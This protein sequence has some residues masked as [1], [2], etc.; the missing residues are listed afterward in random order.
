[1]AFYEPSD[2]CQ[3]PSGVNV[4]KGE[5]IISTDTLGRSYYTLRGGFMVESRAV[6]KPAGNA[7][8]HANI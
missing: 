4:L 6:H 8:S 7:T 3:A 2:P 1:M 5:K